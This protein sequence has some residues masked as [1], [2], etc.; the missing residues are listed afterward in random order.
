MTHVSASDHYEA[1]WLSLCKGLSLC[2]LSQQSFTHPHFS[3]CGLSA[4]ATFLFAVSSLFQPTFSLGAVTQAAFFLASHITN[5]FSFSFYHLVTSSGNIPLPT[6][7]SKFPHI[8]LFLS[9]FLVYFL[10][11]LYVFF[12]LCALWFP[13]RL[14]ICKDWMHV[15]FSHL[16]I[17]ST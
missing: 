14:K 9:H 7:L 3:S 16:S 5:S 2:H 8:L 15:C 11:F 6:F 10:L 12:N 13:T 1:L 17:P 4:T